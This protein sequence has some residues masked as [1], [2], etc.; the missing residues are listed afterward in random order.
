MWADSI[1]LWPNVVMCFL[2]GFLID[3][4]VHL[5]SHFSIHSN[6]AQNLFRFVCRV[7]GARFGTILYVFILT[8]GQLIYAIGVTFNA[9]WM[10][11]LGS[12]VFGIRIASLGV[13]QRNYAMLWFRDKELNTVFGIISLFGLTGV[14]IN[15]W[16]M[17]PLYKYIN[18]WYTGH[19]CLGVVMLIS[20]AVCLM[21]FFC[22]VLLGVLDKRAER[23]LQRNDNP[24]GEIAKF[25]DVKTFKATFWMLLIVGVATD[26]SILPFSALSQ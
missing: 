25:S 19:V 17:E 24:S 16:V 10:I 8:I 21:S 1:S 2:G 15:F 7:F 22:A 11:L 18:Q 4:L 20:F 13:A 6:K 3:R 9:Y 14:T 12:L 5:L 23:I 26:T